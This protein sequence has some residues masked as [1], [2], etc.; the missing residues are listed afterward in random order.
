M[1]LFIIAAVLVASLALTGTA[2]AHDSGSIQHK[3]KYL[4]AKVIKL[5]GKHAPGRDIVRWGMASGKAPSSRAVRHYFNTMRRMILPAPAAKYVYAGSPYQ[6]PART[7]S[8]NPGGLLNKI[9][10]CESGGNPRAV[11]DGG[12]YRGKYQFDRRT[13]AEVGGSGDPAAAP[14]A[15]QD[16]RA[17]MLLAKAGPGRWPV[18]GS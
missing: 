5:H 4:R 6:P 10:S 12:T 9:A 14:E 18:C 8:L 3:N 1:R 7:A 16:K 13:W 15:E 11:S 2:V 17:A